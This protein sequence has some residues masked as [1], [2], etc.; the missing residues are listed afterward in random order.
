MHD[1]APKSSEGLAS[2]FGS[3]IYW[4]WDVGKL[5]HL[6][7]LRPYIHPQGKLDLP[8]RATEG[9]RGWCV[10]KPPIQA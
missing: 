4:L 2:D 9:G 7:H 6:W 8:L 5:Q 10:M 3:A 1:L